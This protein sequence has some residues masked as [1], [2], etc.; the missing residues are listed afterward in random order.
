MS[1]RSYTVVIGVDFSDASIRALDEAL[2]LV[3][4]MESVRVVPVVVLRGGRVSRPE[5]LAANMDRLIEDTRRTLDSLVQ[6]RNRRDDPTRP[7]LT[8]VAMVEFGSPAD[9]LLQVAERERANLLVVGPHTRKDLAR[10]VL[11]SVAQQV[12]RE[13]RCSVIVSRALPSVS[14]EPT[15]EESEAELSTET[16]E[17]GMSLLA[18]PHIDGESVVL[19]L[20]DEKSG[21][22]VVCTFEE[23]HRVR[24][25]GLARRWVTRLS[26]EQRARGAQAALAHSRQEASLYG[27]LF[28]EL[29]R[30]KLSS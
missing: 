7:A 25:E 27:E 11:G 13:A 15:T 17:H 30:R 9:C 23:P 12:A 20:L 22:A 18:A 28:D 1:E 5:S 3:G 24:V 2:D 29:A 16:S 6:E 19:Q 10:A 8:S 21:E 26:A 4:A 14:S